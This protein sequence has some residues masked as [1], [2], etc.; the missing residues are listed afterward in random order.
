MYVYNL[1]A[2]MRLSVWDSGLVGVRE[3]KEENDDM[4]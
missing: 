4:E 3:K 1:K 2:D